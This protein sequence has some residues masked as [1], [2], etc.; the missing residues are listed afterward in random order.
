MKKINEYEKRMDSMLN[1]SLKKTSLKEAGEDDILK[2]NIGTYPW[3]FKKIDGTH[4]FMANDEK[5]IKSGAAMAHHV[6][7]HRGEDY[8]KSLVS[9]LKGGIPTKKLYG[10]GFKGNG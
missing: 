5:A 2:I 6:G 10:K 9:W 8:Y 1:E 3:Y 7:Q 4:F